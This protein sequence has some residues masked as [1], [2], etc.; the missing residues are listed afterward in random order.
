VLQ[1]RVKVPVRE[2]N[3][4]KNWLY[5][6]APV[7]SGTENVR[8]L[9]W[10]TWKEVHRQYSCAIAGCAFPT[11]SLSFIKK[12]TKK[13]HIRLEKF[14]HYICPI[15]LQGRHPDEA[16][17]PIRKRQSLVAKYPSHHALVQFQLQLFRRQKARLTEG[18]VMI[19]F[20]F[21]RFHETTE[22][23]AHSLGVALITHNSKTYHDFFADHSHNYEYTVA[24]MQRFF[25]KERVIQQAQRI[26]VWSDGGLRSKENLYTF[27]RLQQVWRVAINI[28]IFPPHHGHNICDRHF[29]N[30][31]QRLRENQAGQLVTTIETIEGGFKTLKRTKTAILSN[32]DIPSV[33][34]NLE[35]LPEGTQHFYAFSFGNEGDILC[36]H[37][38]LQAP[39]VRQTFIFAN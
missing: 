11:R 23:K 29:G 7:R 13:L 12:L 8:I 3:W 17:F 4:I 35:L 5:E 20:D 18:Q 36:W 34:Y 37:H 28:F 9:P 10:G 25:A 33:H 26:L 21:T 14:D 16:L 31:K 24:V 38:Y 19:V 15:C 6:M 32:I 2:E 30:G 39:C 22:L 1:T 27:Y